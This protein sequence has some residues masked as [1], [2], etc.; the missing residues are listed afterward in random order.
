MN[1][2]FSY[3][4]KY[5]KNYKNIIELQNYVFENNNIKDKR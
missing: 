5:S 1:S 4:K 3:L 2:F